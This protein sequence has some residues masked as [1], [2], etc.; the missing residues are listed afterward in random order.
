M[1]IKTINLE[2][3]KELRNKD[4]EYLIFQG[5]GGD[6]NDWIDGVSNLLKDENI[7]PSDF[8]FNEVYKVENRN[9]TNLVFD[10]NNKDINMG[11]LAIFRLQLREEFG[12]MWLSDY[13]DNYLNC[14]ISI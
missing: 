8:R 7:V 1:E 5:C 10:L 14:N 9:C 2:E 12:A 4:Y 6:L 3:L 13:I 11:K